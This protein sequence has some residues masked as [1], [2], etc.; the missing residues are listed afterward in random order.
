[1]EAESHLDS[2][3]FKDFGPTR[4]IKGCAAR[5]AIHYCFPQNC[6]CSSVVEHLLAKEDVA[7]SSLVTRSSLRL[8]RSAKRRLE[9]CAVALAKADRPKP[10]SYGWQ[11]SLSR[12][13]VYLLKSEYSPK[14]PYV[15]STG[16]LRQRLEDHNEGRSPHAAKF[17]PWVLV[18]ICICTGRNRDRPREVSEV[19]FRTS[20]HQ[21][22]L[23]LAEGKTFA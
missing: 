13:Y 20:I 4:V 19:R 23:S 11:A 2:K 3:I 1:M 8:K 5:L 12:H 10:P 17:R 6:G 22:A 21:T 16:D 18:P 9:R 7:S 14:Q 15:G